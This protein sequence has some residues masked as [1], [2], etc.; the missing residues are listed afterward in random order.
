MDEELVAALLP[1][2]DG[3]VAADALAAG[4]Q[5]EVVVVDG[6]LEE[7]G[8]GRI[9][10][11]PLRDTALLDWCIKLLEDLRPAAVAA[12]AGRPGAAG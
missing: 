5:P 12:G 4:E 7:E 2:L 3:D 8:D 10:S 11:P 6:D 1:G 9:G